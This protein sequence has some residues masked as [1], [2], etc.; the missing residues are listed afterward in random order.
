M[1]YLRPSRGYP[2]VLFRMLFQQ[3]KL[4][5]QWTSCALK[6]TICRSV[7]INVHLFYEKYTR[8][9]EAKQDGLGPNSHVGPLRIDSIGEITSPRLQITK[10]LVNHGV[11]RTYGYEIRTRI[12]KNPRRFLFQYSIH[13]KQFTVESTHVKFHTLFF[14]YRNFWVANLNLQ[15]WIARLLS[16]SLLME[17]GYQQIHLGTISN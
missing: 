9:L 10:F 13:Q 2:G 14:V 17:Y 5:V 15:A 11:N 3:S 6:S 4:F 7:I 1:S 16:I 8:T 12:M